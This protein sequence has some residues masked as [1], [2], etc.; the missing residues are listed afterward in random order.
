MSAKRWRYVN[1][2]SHHHFSVEIAKILDE[3]CR[4]FFSPNLFGETILKIITLTPPPKKK[5]ADRFE[6]ILE[7]SS[8]AACLFFAVVVAASRNKF[9][10]RFRKHVT[11]F[12]ITIFF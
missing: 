8:E 11:F 1:N 10:Q 12:I 3:N 2:Q 5:S 9:L 6:E 7:L 4:K